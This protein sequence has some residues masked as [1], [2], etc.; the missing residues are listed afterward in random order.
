VKRDESIA[1]RRISNEEQAV[2]QALLLWADLERPRVKI[3]AAA[4][5]H[6]CLQNYG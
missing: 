4:P 2:T 3:L 1:S 5:M 6:T